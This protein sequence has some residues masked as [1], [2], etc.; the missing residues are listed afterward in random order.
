MTNGKNEKG[1]K[2]ARM[3]KGLSSVRLALCLFLVLGVSSVI[4][5]LL[6]QGAD[7][8][9]VQQHFGERTFVLMR[10]FGLFDLFHSWWF[11]AI[12]CLLAINLFFCSFQRLPSLLKV[13]SL[14][15][16]KIEEGRE[17]LLPSRS[18][19]ACSGE[20][21]RARV[22]EVL[23]S[24]GYR[25][26]W[27]GEK[28]PAH[29]LAA[30]GRWTRLG[31]YIVHLSILLVLLGATIGAVFGFRG[32]V[33]ISEG[34]TVDSFQSQDGKGWRK[35]SFSLRCDDF[36][37][38]YYEGTHRPKE[39]RSE[40]TVIEGG[41]EVLKKA[42]VV[43][44]PLSYK[45]IYFYQSSFGQTGG[46]KSIVLSLEDPSRKEP[47]RFEVLAEKPFPLE[48]TD[49]S[50]RM[51]R[52][53]PDFALDERFS[54]FSRSE[55]FNN[56]A[57]EIEI[58]K[59]GRPLFRT[60]VFARF[61]E[62]HGPREGG[63]Q[64]FRLL[65]YKATEYTGLQV[66]YDPGIGWVWAGFALMVFGLGISLFMGERRIW[67]HISQGEGKWNLQLAGQSRKAREAF[68]REFGTICQELEGRV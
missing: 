61:G 25:V 65:D 13:I 43:N 26:R 67:V 51:L 16:V 53:F 11:I 59:G 56:P 1:K 8:A 2:L 29:A 3:W 58:S 6:P 41:K 52:F 19:F 22:E 63:N 27:G 57:A 9:L 7:P 48:G 45:G 30:K 38:S 24:K 18:T 12:L 50:I 15:P 47:L 68:D 17:K 54:A 60:W 46:V 31:P 42:L 10:L 37:A 33:N 32:Y 39:F 34:E 4:G 28:S 35:L 5:T 49:Y 36:E 64:R 23:R 14:P 21:P 66:S 55:E 44:D 20:D 40:I 62:F